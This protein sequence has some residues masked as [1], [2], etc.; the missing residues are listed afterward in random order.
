MPQITRLA[1]EHDEDNRCCNV[2]YYSHSTLLLP[3]A[4]RDWYDPPTP[5]SPSCPPN[6]QGPVPGTKLW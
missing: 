3:N 4:H 6:K 5:Q 2:F 1:V